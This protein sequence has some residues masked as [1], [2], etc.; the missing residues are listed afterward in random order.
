MVQEI[1]NHRK[2][3][4]W[5]ITTIG[6]FVTII[7]GCG[8]STANTPTTSGIQNSPSGIS[9]QNQS[10]IEIGVNGHPFA[11]VAYEDVGVQQQLDL[12]KGMGGKWY[13]VDCYGNAIQPEGISAISNLVAEAKSRGISVLPV[14]FPNVDI[15]NENDL[16]KIYATAYQYSKALVGQF[17]NDVHVWELSNEQ[18][19][20]AIIN[21]GEVSTNGTVWQYGVPDG[22]GVEQY[23]ATRTQ[24]AVAL[25]AGLSD[26]VNAADPNARRI[27]NASWLHYGFLKILV[28]N[29]VNF[30]V[31]GWHWYSDMGD[32]TNA[33]GSVNV[34]QNLNQFQKPIWFT[35]SNRRNGSQ[36][37]NGESEQNSYITTTLKTYMSYASQYNI[38]KIMFYELLD[39]PQLGA[40]NPEAYYGLVRLQRGASGKWEVMSMKSAYGTLQSLS[41]N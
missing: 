26:G 17:K 35:E 34:L 25:L 24:K 29:K 16:T 4:N 40:A 14:I 3:F 1:S 7:S 6:I 31:I 22:D 30:E 18:D 28:L 12:V 8:G 2:C 23:E 20:Y 32:I 41:T 5:L 19:G 10:A 39:E 33:K 15:N 11:Q 37:D 13:R 9:S 38:E 21:K 36:G 27:I